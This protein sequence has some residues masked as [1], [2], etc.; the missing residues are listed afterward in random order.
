[1]VE[2]RERSKQS[3]LM[4][5]LELSSPLL[6][7]TLDQISAINKWLGGKRVTLDG[8]KI[9][10]K[11]HPKEKSLSIVDLGCGRGDM[12]R[13]IAKY[14]RENGYQFI[15][16][17][18]DA[19]QTTIDYA[20]SLSKEFEEIEYIKLDVLSEEFSTKKFDIA[21]CTLFLHHFNDA[22]AL[23]F[24][25][26][27]LKNVEKGIIINDL[28]R[29]RLAYFL[30]KIL[31]IFI[32]NEMVRVDGATSI[33]RSFTKTDLLRFSEQIKHKSTI[34]WKWVFRYQW[35]IKKNDCKNN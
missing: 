5:N 17:G 9:L 10:I 30:F 11:N 23:N 24:I 6:L 31:S 7:K 35:M 22:T 18:I 28:H 34:K 16:L 14:G 26:S 25:Q 32:H 3:E 2:I 19:N 1:M 4:D 27:T 8:V 15:L 29:C 33:L 13:D 12:L 20:N 21:L